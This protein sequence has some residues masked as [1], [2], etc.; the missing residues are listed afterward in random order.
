[1]VYVLYIEINSNIPNNVSKYIL[2]HKFSHN[3]ISQSFCI[4]TA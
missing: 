3:Q 1:M 4:H 2:L